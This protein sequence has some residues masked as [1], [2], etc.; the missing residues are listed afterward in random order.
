MAFYIEGQ[1]FENAKGDALLIKCL[2]VSLLLCLH[3]LRS[4]NINRSCM[5]SITQNIFDPFLCYNF[6]LV[7]IFWAYSKSSRSIGSFITACTAIITHYYTVVTDPVGNLVTNRPARLGQCHF[8]V[9]AWWM[10]ITRTSTDLRRTYSGS[11]L[12]FSFFG[13]AFYCHN[14]LHFYGVEMS[15]EQN[16][17]GVQHLSL[18]SFVS[19]FF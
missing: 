13:N 19:F 4:K 15:E 10:V 9:P 8:D 12:G 16:W 3:V 2:I 6:A 14:R 7:F 11:W 18:A 5:L 1:Q 17:H